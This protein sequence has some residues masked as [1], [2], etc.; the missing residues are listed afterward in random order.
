MSRFIFILFICLYSTILAQDTYPYFSD[1]KKQLEFEKKRIYINEVNEKE[2]II[3]GGSKDNLL[4]L[5]D[6]NHYLKLII[7][8]STKKLKAINSRINVIEMC[9]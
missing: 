3:S 2:M 4:R 7:E 5:I 8:D 6:E 1:A 9:L